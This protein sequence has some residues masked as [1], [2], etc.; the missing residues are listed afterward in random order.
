MEYIQSRILEIC[1][2]HKIKKEI[3]DSLNLIDIRY[4]TKKYL[5]Q[6]I[7]NGKLQMTLIVT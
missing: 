3:D 1:N 7:E 5:K 2:A 4:L 6:L